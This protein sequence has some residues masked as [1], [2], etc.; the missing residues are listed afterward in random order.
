MFA[1]DGALEIAQALVQFA[2]GISNGVETAGELREKG[3]GVGNLPSHINRGQEGEVV[4]G[5]ALGKPVLEI[6]DALVELIDLLDGPGPLKVR[7]GLGNGPRGF[8][9]VASITGGVAKKQIPISWSSV[10][11]K[12][13]YSDMPPNANGEMQTKYMRLSPCRMQNGITPDTAILEGPVADEAGYYGIQ[14]VGVMN[15]WVIIT[16]KK[17]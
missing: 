10:L 5:Q 4:F 6:L 8:T 9:R 13:C 17:N 16:V 1:D 3:G 15:N 7:A 14:L 11:M 2:L 12:Y